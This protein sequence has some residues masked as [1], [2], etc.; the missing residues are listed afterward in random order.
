MR[1]LIFAILLIIAPLAFATD[2]ALIT[3]V[4]G[5][6]RLIKAQ[7]DAQKA[8]P[9]LKLSIDDRLVLNKAAQIQIVVFSQNQ[10]E[11]WRGAGEVQITEHG[12]ASSNLKPE[13]YALPA[14]VSR[15]LAKIPATGDTTRSGMVVIRALP[16]PEKRRQLETEYQALNPNDLTAQIYYLTG[17]IELNDM[18]RAEEVLSALKQQNHNPNAQAIVKHFSP[19]ITQH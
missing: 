11:T 14:I 4:Q 19:L 1:T 18:E 3:Q 10:Q 2:I 8:L 6:V 5:D 17:L 7:G 13:R 9:L 16:N 12:G 15:Q